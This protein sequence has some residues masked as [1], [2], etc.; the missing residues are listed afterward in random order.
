[1]QMTIQMRPERLF[2]MFKKRKVMVIIQVIVIMS[3]HVVFDSDTIQSSSLDKVTSI[4]ESKEGS[5][6]I[7]E[8]VRKNQKLIDNIVC[9]QNNERTYV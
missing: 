4:F 1:M 9:R 5:V 3:G 6:T 7:P 8:L 2:S